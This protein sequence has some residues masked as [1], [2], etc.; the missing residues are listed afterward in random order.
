MAFGSRSS[1]EAGDLGSEVF[2]SAPVTAF[3]SPL[4]ASP[5]ALVFTCASNCRKLNATPVVEVLVPA[6]AAVAAPL[7]APPRPRARRLR[8]APPRR[9]AIPPEAPEDV[10]AAL[11]EGVGAVET[12]L[13]A[14]PMCS[15]RLRAL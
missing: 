14:T 8:R 4:E 12:D 15:M 9:A 6:A 10:L 1:S 13:R 5:A 11:A 2:P 3:G 7:P